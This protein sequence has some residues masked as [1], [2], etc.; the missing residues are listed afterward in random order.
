M[1]ERARTAWP[2]TQEPSRASPA[3]P[4]RPSSS[5]WLPTQP[6]A[7]AVQANGKSEWATRRRA[8]PSPQRPLRETRAS[9]QRSEQCGAACR[10]PPAPACRRL[11]S[12][13]LTRLLN[14]GHNLPQGGDGTPLA[15]PTGTVRLEQLR[16]FVASVEAALHTARDR[17]AT[18]ARR[19]LA[20]GTVW[21][22]RAPGAPPAPPDPSATSVCVLTEVPCPPPDL[23][24]SQGRC[25]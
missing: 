15:T 8:S 12:S 3:P 24:S 21:V 5:C 18:G 2:K 16:R 23:A 4:V 9:K 1:C 7:P 6:A 17:L 19:G 11:S 13:P 14:S 25:S 20:A 22:L 10:C